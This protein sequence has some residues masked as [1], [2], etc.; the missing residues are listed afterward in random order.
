[1]PVNYTTLPLQPPPPLAQGATEAQRAEWRD[2]HRIVSGYAIA[3]AQQATAE[4]TLANT[5]A[6]QALARA[7]GAPVR[8]PTRAELAFELVKTQ[9]QATIMTNSTLVNGADG[10]VAAYVLKF[11]NA[12]EG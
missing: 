8:K 12:V 1:M 6:Q 7:I 3:A 2:L 11:P 5:E 4:A 9:P 10:I